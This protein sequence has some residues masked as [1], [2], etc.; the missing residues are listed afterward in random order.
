MPLNLGAYKLGSVGG[1]GDLTGAVS[2]LAVSG[3]DVTTSVATNTI[4]GR[5]AA[6]SGVLQQLTPAQVNTLLGVQTLATQQAAGTA[7]VQVKMTVSNAQIK[8]GTAIDITG[9]TATAG[10]YWNVIESVVNFTGAGVPFTNKM[11]IINSTGAI[12]SNEQWSDNSILLGGGNV[13]QEMLNIKGVNGTSFIVND[14]MQIQF[15]A[16]SAVGAGQVVVSV[17]AMLVTA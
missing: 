17:T 14:K 9:L 11:F 10:A 4:A 12:G 15:N 13:F 7:L 3:T 1:G 8:A 2:P 16:N 5:I 6:G